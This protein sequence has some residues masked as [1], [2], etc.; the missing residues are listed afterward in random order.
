[1]SL[2]VNGECPRLETI[3]IPLAP[4]PLRMEFGAV[5]ASSV[6]IG[7]RLGKMRSSSDSLV[8]RVAS[9]SIT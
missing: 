5:S 6:P 4:A 3:E 1:M 9:V 8:P 2:R 7:A